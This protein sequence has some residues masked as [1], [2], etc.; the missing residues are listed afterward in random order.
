MKRS[1]RKQGAYSQATR[2][3]RL[4]D[5]LRGRYY[6]CLLSD[7]AA[8]FAV[9][10]R[11]MRRDLAT[12]EDAGY[13]I[14]YRPSDDGRTK[15]RLTEGR[16]RG[17]ALTIRERY[18]LLAVRRVFDCLLDTPLYEDV[19]SIVSKIAGSLPDKE[20]AELEQFGERFI[21]VPEGGTKP[22]RG[23]EDVLDA[24]LT[25]TIRRGQ[26]RYRYNASSGVRAGI[27]EPYAMLLYKQGLYVIAKP[28]DEDRIPNVYAAERFKDAE[29]LRGTSFKVPDTFKVD[30][31]FQGAFGIFMG[32]KKH[33]VVVDFAAEARRLV[34]ARVWHR[35]QKIRPLPDGGAR[36]EFDVD[37]F[38]QVVTW[39]LGW[40][41]LAR[42]VE[43]P[44]LVAK[45]K[46]EIAA[47]GK[48][49]GSASRN[50]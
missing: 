3:L 9:T 33:H 36:L 7:L 2:L 22:Y 44:E 29:Y 30:E 41:P 35:T 11:Q 32:K 50:A 26:V 13:S 48:K 49:Y 43:P 20:R 15:V 23:K 46:E 34:D 10:P 47:M 37:N 28:V 17:V 40:G 27:I 6:G 12:L 38:T 31:F 5:H 24:L 42:V 19:H 45:M 1:G 39:A 21:F 14:D 4:L 16:T 25:G 8:D 18:A